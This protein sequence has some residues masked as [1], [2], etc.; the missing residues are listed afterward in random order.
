MFKECHITFIKNTLLIIN[1]LIKRIYPKRRE[2][3]RGETEKE[4]E[5]NKIWKE[6]LKQKTQGRPSSLHVRKWVPLSVL[7]L[8]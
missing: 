2:R 7:L 1:E 6:Y 5:M 8:F 4:R 3:E